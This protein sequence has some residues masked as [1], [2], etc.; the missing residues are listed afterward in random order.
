[1][2]RFN[3][4]QEDMLIP[5]NGKSDYQLVSNFRYFNCKKNRLVA[6]VLVADDMSIIS[7]FPLQVHLG[8]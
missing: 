4:A 2:Y 1:M 5:T 8:Q 7:I 6:V 3:H